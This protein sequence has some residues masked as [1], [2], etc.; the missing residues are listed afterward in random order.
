[1]RARFLEA[2]SWAGL[3]S[4][5]NWLDGC[6]RG[7]AQK[8]PPREFIAEARAECG[9]LTHRSLDNCSLSSQSKIVSSSEKR[10]WRVS[11]CCYILSRVKVI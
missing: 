10:L 1:M 2:C 6:A 8:F 4:C 5:A 11:E 9:E 3:V 7:E